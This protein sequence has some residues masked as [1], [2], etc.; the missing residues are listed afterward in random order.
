M[1]DAV[2]ECGL[3]SKIKKGKFQ[4]S[5]RCQDGE[6]CELCNYVNIT[7][8]VKT[9]VAA[10]NR[11]AFIRGV[12]NYAITVAPCADLAQAKAV[13]RTI[14][15][16]D[17]DYE[18]PGSVVYR[19][20][21]HARVFKYFDVFESDPLGDWAVEEDIRRFLGAVQTTFGKVRKVSMARS[22]MTAPYTR[23]RRRL[24]RSAA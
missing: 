21:H 13:G 14:V 9:L 17:W 1:I 8:G 6:D 5:H 7:D 24:P 20:G 15:P 18:N 2:I 3:F 11:K 16:E 19:A 10:Y 4:Y 22:G 23:S 12:N